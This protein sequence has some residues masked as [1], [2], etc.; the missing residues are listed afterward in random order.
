MIPAIFITAFCTVAQGPLQ[1]HETGKYLLGGLNGFLTF[2]LSVISFTKLD[3][4]AQAY[5][6]TA[7]QYDKLQSSTEFLSGKYLLF[8]RNVELNYKKSSSTKKS[9]TSNHE[10]QDDVDSDKSPIPK[11]FWGRSIFLGETHLLTVSFSRFSSF[12]LHNNLL[13]LLSVS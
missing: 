2:L 11:E 3:A 9:H 8:Y 12:L 13:H 1:C 6:I 4:S 5:K 10:E 7:H